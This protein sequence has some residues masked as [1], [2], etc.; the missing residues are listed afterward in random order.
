MKKAI[1]SPEYQS[2]TEVYEVKR[3]ICAPHLPDFSAGAVCSLASAQQP[4]SRG[5]M[6]K[7]EG[8]SLKQAG[9]LIMT[10]FLFQTCLNNCS[11]PA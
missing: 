5:Q 9:R 1:V 11:F 3:Q 2:T 4:V 7:R 10:G 6:D 8:I